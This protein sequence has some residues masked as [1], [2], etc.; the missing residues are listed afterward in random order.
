MNSQI[1]LSDIIGA[2]LAPIVEAILTLV[3]GILSFVAELLLPFF[4]PVFEAI[5]F[6]LAAVLFFIQSLIW[7]TL[8]ALGLAWSARGLSYAAAVLSA[9]CFVYLLAMITHPMLWEGRAS[10]AVYFPQTAVHSALIT[11]P[12]SLLLAWMLYES[13]EDRKTRRDAPRPAKAPR[14][15]RHKTAVRLVIIALFS[16]GGFIG[17]SQFQS[18]EEK[19]L[20]PC[21][22]AGQLRAVA[23]GYLSNKGHETTAGIVK[24]KDCT[25]RH[26]Q[27]H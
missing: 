21:S 2:I 26:V 17:W 11:A 22:T 1:V 16:I 15:K 4:M 18:T 9:V 23:S 25:T 10:S 20:P 24:S 6:A 27:Q 13:P 12:L 5:A 3:A 8:T 14:S 7:G 19:T